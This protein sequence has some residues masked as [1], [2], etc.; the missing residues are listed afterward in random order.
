MTNDV[1]KAFVHWMFGC[2]VDN[3]LDRDYR[4]AAED[5]T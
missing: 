5:G 4:M 1:I 3:E 2:R